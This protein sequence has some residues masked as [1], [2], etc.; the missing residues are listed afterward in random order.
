MHTTIKKDTIVC[1]LV[2]AGVALAEIGNAYLTYKWKP[3]TY[4]TDGIEN[5]SYND[6]YDAV[7]DIILKL[8]LCIG[9]RIYVSARILKNI[10]NFYTESLLIDFV[11]SAFFNPFVY[12]LGKIKLIEIT[13]C[14]Y[15]LQIILY[16]VWK[17]IHQRDPYPIRYNKESR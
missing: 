10:L 6:F 12:H 11:Y 16:T 4:L 1:I 8:A 14:V 15:L 3:A 7:G 17:N 2:V 9:L 5:Y 13:F